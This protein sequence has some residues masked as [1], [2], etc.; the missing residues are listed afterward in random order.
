MRDKRDQRCQYYLRL[1]LNSDVDRLLFESNLDQVFR[2]LCRGGTAQVILLKDSHRVTL[3]E[4][5]GLTLFR[6]K[7]DDLLHLLLKANI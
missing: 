1:L 3:P 2:F 6:K 5:H 4:K 7:L